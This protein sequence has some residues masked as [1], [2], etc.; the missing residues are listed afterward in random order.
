[1]A[2]GVAQE[3]RTSAAVASPVSETL[4][5]PV[6]GGSSIHVFVA[7]NGGGPTPSFVVTDNQGNTYTARGPVLTDGS[8]HFWQQFTADHVSAG[9]LT[10][11]S[12][13]TGGGTSCVIIAR[14][15]SGTSG[16]DT[17]NQSEA[18]INPGTDTGTSGTAT[19]SFQPGLISALAIGT[20]GALSFSAGTGFTLGTAFFATQITEQ[21][22]YTS[23]AAKAATISATGSGSENTFVFAGFFKESIAGGAG[24]QIYILP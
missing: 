23:T 1:M 10:I 14:E 20:V 15:I 17:N 13:V 3:L 2:I 18:A 22:R 19:P 8:S 4:T 12:T 16:F 6:A 21:L 7:S 5:N 11:T 9:S 24:S